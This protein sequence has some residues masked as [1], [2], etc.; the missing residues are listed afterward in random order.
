MM[1]S[2]LLRCCA[3]IFL[4]HLFLIGTIGKEF[5]TLDHIRTK[6]DD[7]TQQQTVEDMIF[8]TVGDRFSDFSVVV[9]SSFLPM[10]K[11]AFQLDTV[12]S[13]IVI[14]GTTG[15]AAAHGFNHYLKYYARCQVS[16]TVQQVHLPGVL[17]PVTPAVTIVTVNRY[18]Y[19]Q[20]VCTV[21]Y[22]FVWWD[23]SRWERH[24]DWMALSGINLPLAFNG[25]EAIWQKVYLSL[26]F[27]Q[28]DLDEHFGGPA[29]LAWARMG[30]IRGWGGPLPQ[31]WHQNQLELQHKILARMR[32]FGMIPVLPGFAG[33]VPAAIT[34]LYPNA[35]VSRL[36][37]GRFEDP[38]CCTYLLDPQDPLFSHI[39]GMFITEMIKEFNGTNHIYNADTF[40][41]MRPQSSEPNYLSKAGAAVYAGMLAG[42]PQAIW[43]MQGWLFQAR[44]F[45]QP[46]QTKAL[47][48]SVPEGKMIVLDLFGEVQ[49]IYNTTDSFYGQPFIW[50]MLHNFGGNLGMYGTVKTVNQGP[51]LARKYLGSTMVGTGLTP[52]GIDQN[53]IMYELMNEVAWMPQP[54]Q[55]L[56]NW[57]SDYAWSRYGVKNSNA[58]LG[59]QILLKSV[60]DCENGFKDHCDSVVVHRPDLHKT[61]RSWYKQ[62]DVFTAWDHF[63]SASNDLGLMDSFRYDLVDVTRQALQEWAYIY[64]QDLMET[65]KSGDLIKF[66]DAA[67]IFQQTLSDMD[68]ILATHQ[69]FLLGRWIE[70]AKSLATNDQE[71][72][73]YEFNARNQITLWGPNGEIVDYANKQWSGLV[74]DYYA[75]RW[76]LMTKALTTAL[77]EGK[78]FNHTAFLLDVFQQVEQPFTLANKAYPNYPTG[79]TLQVAKELHQK[80]RPRTL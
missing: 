36:Q 75:E 33:H 67:E 40:N 26:G 30:N 59:W 37:W 52:E 57:A 51:F 58:S 21:S 24:L 38:Y 80:Y 20:N 45:W 5:P 25:Q 3:V 70:D 64:Y 78:K 29:F 48:Q 61:Q 32:N 17:P 31:S 23:W 2:T 18:R 44:D 72:S 76:S 68:R 14:R 43:L 22:S 66:R 11:E 19:Y 60:Y 79:D 63:V 77:M 71:R 1:T 46:A 12:G 55:I 27:T 69:N 35:S 15:V 41:E 54:F 65:Y 4:T 28:K 16:W 13:K 8:R 50:C 49:P 47:L 9:D 39:G 74:A 6:V 10:G 56:D 53:Y 62:E 7:A 42:D 34:R 73:L